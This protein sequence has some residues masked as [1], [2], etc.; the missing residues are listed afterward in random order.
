M[1]YRKDFDTKIMISILGF[2]KQTFIQE[3]FLY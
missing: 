2:L 3:R 1:N